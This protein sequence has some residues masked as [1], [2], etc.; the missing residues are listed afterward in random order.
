[1]R[2]HAWSYRLALPRLRVARLLR[3][4]GRV[5]LGV[6]PG[7]TGAL[8]ALFDDGGLAWVMDMP[9]VDK[10]VN[11]V[12]LAQELRDRGISIAV[13]ERVASMP[14][15]GVSSVFKFGKGYGQVLGVLAALEIPLVEPTPSQWKSAMNLSK[16]KELSRALAI[17]TWPSM[18][19]FFERKKDADRA[20]AA[21]MALWH[22][23]KT[24]NLPPHVDTPK[25]VPPPKPGQGR[26][27]HRRS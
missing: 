5:I 26:T 6:D 9:V 17:K 11:A 18:A 4:R 15:Q 3:R 8:A 7:L 27:L 12:T 21:L 2:M 1:M 13:V 22:L 19:K 14:G 20:E 24:Q 10:N 25:R 16:D 23:Q